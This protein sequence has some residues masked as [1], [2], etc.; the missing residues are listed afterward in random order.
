MGNWYEERLEPAQPFREN[1]EN[2]YQREEEEAISFPSDTNK[3]IP[4][5]RIKR[6]QPW[7]TKG[8]IADDGFKEFRSVN[9]TTIDPANLANY[10]NQG[11]KRSLIKTYD[12]K[13][14]Y[15]ENSKYHIQ[16]FKSNNYKMLTRENMK[17]IEEER[18][19]NK[20]VSDFGSTFRKHD[21][22]H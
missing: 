10:Y 17:H 18:I 12:E 9:G 7:V 5:A 1:I 8:V 15:P 14:E 16:T 3:L 6:N 22:T 13:I 2:K 21:E 20:N 19:V 4:L 11:D